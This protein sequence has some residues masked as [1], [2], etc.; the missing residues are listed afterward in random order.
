VT[1]AE[2]VTIA[3]PAL[4]TGG[5]I[6]ALVTLYRARADRATTIAAGAEQVVVTMGRALQAM[7][8]RA[9]AAETRAGTAEGALDRMEEQCRQ[10]QAK[11]NDLQSELTRYRKEVEE[12]DG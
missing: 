8:A 1:L 12:L 6:S 11:L 2:L 3:T 10:L 9:L 4:L 5:G 7:E